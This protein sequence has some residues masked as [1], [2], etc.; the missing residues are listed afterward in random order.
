MAKV[1]SYIRT[2]QECGHKQP[3]VNPTNLDHSS[4]SRYQERI[5]KNCKSISLD[6]GSEVI[7]ESEVL[8]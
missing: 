4:F 2:C 8:K 1:Q 7:V 3:D 6:Y 5:C